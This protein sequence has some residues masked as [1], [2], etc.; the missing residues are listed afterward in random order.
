VWKK[1][2]R[3]AEAMAQWESGVA[4]KPADKPAFNFLDS[5]SGRREPTSQ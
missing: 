1:G 3:E 4:D 5:Y 2:V